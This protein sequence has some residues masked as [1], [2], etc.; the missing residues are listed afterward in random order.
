VREEGQA[1]FSRDE[2]AFVVRVGGHI[3]RGL[4][5]ALLLEAAGDAADDHAPGMLVLRRDLSIES[6]TAQA[7]SWLERLPTDRGTGLELPAVIY[8]V[9]RR[10]RAATS[11][12]GINRPARARVRLASGGWLVVHAAP[13]ADHPDG[14]RIAVVLAP[15]DPLEIAPLR[16]ELHGLSRRE[17]DVAR[18]LARGLSTEE[19]AR[20]L[21]ISRHTAKD[22]IKSVYTKLDVTSRHELTAK[23]F[24]EH[25]VPSFDEGSVREF[26]PKHTAS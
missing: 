8:A 3:A 12:G 4:R 1:D 7:D 19:I 15:A 25:H 5:A 10:A 23:L 6:R 26:A 17:L 11:D 2:I 21:W 14:D 9:A 18:L 24:F 20:R 13:L 16:L 22:H